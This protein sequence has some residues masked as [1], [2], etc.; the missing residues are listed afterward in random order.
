MDAVIV[1]PPAVIILEAGVKLVPDE[2]VKDAGVA[3]VVT[4]V[5]MAEVGMAEVGMAEVGVVAVRVTGTCVDC[6]VGTAGLSMVMP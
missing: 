3:C 1:T 4:E 5:G 6:G 2:K